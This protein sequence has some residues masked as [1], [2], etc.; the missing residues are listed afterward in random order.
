MLAAAPDTWLAMERAAV[1]LARA[2]GYV[3]AGTVEYLYLPEER[4]FYFLE[5]N[6]RL[7][8][9][10]REQGRL[11]RCWPACLHDAPL[12]LS[13]FLPPGRAPRV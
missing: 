2:V 9:R 8:A 13:P 5:L 10:G 4:T 3:N 6:P 12:T 7:Q 11:S 1:A